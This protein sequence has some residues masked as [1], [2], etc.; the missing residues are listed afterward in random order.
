FWAGVPE[1]HVFGKGKPVR[2]HLL[3]VVEYG[4]RNWTENLHFR[5]ALRASPELAAEYNALKLYLA[6]CYPEERA[7]YTQEKADFIRRIRER[8]P[9]PA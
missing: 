9:P 2:T 1:H 6:E 4:G 5:D 7:R 8:A 3:H